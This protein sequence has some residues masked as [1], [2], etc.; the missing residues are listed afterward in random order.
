MP[1]YFR[2]VPD[3]DYV[4]RDPNQ[5]Q[6]SEY[7]PVKNLFRRG[8]LREDIFGNLSYFTKYKIIGDERPDNVAFKIY[9]DETL[10]WVVLL[11]NN[12]LNI[13]TEWPLPQVIFDKVMLEKYGSY[14]ELYNGIH[15]YETNEIR[16]SSGNLILPSGIIMSSD[17]G[18]GNNF[19]QS[20][21]IERTN[22]IFYNSTNNDIAILTDDSIEGIKVGSRVKIRGS[23]EPF[24]NSTFTLNEIRI[25]NPDLET[26]T[27]FII[28]VSPTFAPETSTI[29]ITG[30]ESFEFLSADPIP[31]VSSYYYEYYDIGLGTN[32]LVSSEKI[33]KPITNY[34]QES[35]LEE[36]KRN[37]FILKPE[38][39]NIIFN[40]MEEIMKYKK[41]STQYVNRTLKRGEN[42]RLY[43]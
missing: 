5:R 28:N 24:L 31:Q 4:S 15:H 29:E 25:G 17:W 26:T 13:Q 36:K 3:F 43:S 39:L 20:Y 9:N 12:I 38:Y 14:D 16:D 41:G 6:I 10:D 33:A 21:I 19:I 11:S 34:E 40:D 32:V 30:N 35:R 27:A 7:A 37:I 22:G 23:S 2:Q 18:S 42:I 8:K 1:S